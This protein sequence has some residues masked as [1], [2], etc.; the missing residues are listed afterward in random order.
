MVQVIEFVSLNNSV[1]ANLVIKEGFGKFVSII[2]A[3]A[4]KKSF[5]RLNLCAKYMAFQQSK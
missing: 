5:E 1:A 2:F 3:T 4:N